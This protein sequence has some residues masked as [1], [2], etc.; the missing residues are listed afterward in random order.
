MKQKS[1]FLFLVPSQRPIQTMCS[2]I[3][4]H[5]LDKH[6]DLYESVHTAEGQSSS[7]AKVVT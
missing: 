5:C 2:V 3:E 6:R 1:V 4:T 7:I